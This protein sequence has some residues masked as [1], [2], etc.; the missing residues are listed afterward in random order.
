MPHTLSVLLVVALAVTPAVAADRAAPAAVPDP[1][2]ADRAAPDPR[3]AAAYRPPVDAPI[4][5]RF[6]PPSS[7]YGPGNRG[8]DYATRPG[9]VVVA[10]AAGEVVFAGLVG[11][12]RH[13]VVRH[14]DGIRTSYSFLA[15]VLVRRGDRVQAGQPVG[16]AGPTLHFGARLGDGY[17][18]PLLLFRR[19]AGAAHL[20]PDRVTPRE[21]AARERA[22]LVRGLPPQPSTVGTGPVRARAGP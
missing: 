11:R 6:R 12:T 17:I 18:D 10:A 7:P 1:P 4:V 19:P 21:T 14:A 15:T 5:D 13:V 16:T 2:V 20:V 3:R 22:A 9:Q 8:V